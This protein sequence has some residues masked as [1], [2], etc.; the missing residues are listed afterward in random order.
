M[1]FSCFRLIRIKKHRPSSLTKLEKPNFHWRNIIKATYT[2]DPREISLKLSQ[3]TRARSTDV[4]VAASRLFEAIATDT[5]K[6][7][8][9]LPPTVGWFVL[10]LDAG[11][12]DSDAPAMQIFG[13]NADG[14]LIFSVQSQGFHYQVCELHRGENATLAY[15]PTD[16]TV[17][18]DYDGDKVL[19]SVTINK[20]QKFTRNLIA[21]TGNVPKSKVGKGE[22]VARP[23]DDQGVNRIYLDHSLVNLHGERVKI[24]FARTEHKAKTTYP[25]HAHVDDNVRIICSGVY[26]FTIFDP[27]SGAT[28]NESIVSSGDTIQVPAGYPYI[29]EVLEPGIVINGRSNF[30]GGATAEPISLHYKMDSPHMLSQSGEVTSLY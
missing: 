15:T 3:L 25:L 17:T 18:I 29:E 19:L 7:P 13:T 22:Q 4:E 20:T 6:R 5:T 26:R 16:T 23:Y 28:L 2:T 8:L 10:T 14:F 11:V 9:I 12:G 27:Q 24:S 21:F 1:R 30:T